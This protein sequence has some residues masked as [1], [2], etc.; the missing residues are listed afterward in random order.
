VV[1]RQP[2]IAVQRNQLLRQRVQIHRPI[3]SGQETVNDDDVEPRQ[4]LVVTR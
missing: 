4:R 1:Q 3:G 2:A